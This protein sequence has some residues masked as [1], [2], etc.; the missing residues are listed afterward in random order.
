MMLSPCVTHLPSET[1]SMYSLERNALL[2]ITCSITDIRYKNIAPVPSTLMYFLL[3]ELKV[4]QICE[5]GTIDR[6]AKE[7]CLSNLYIS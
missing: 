3:H 6:N 7:E 2:D 1:F 4:E 5:S